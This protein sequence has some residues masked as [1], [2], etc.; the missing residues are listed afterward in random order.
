MKI[1]CPGILPTGS[2][3]NRVA[4]AFCN[5]C[6][7]VNLPRR[8]MPLHEV[9]I[10][11]RMSRDDANLQRS[12][13]KV[14]GHCAAF[15]RRLVSATITLGCPHM[16]NIS[17]AM[18]SIAT[19]EGLPKLNGAFVARSWRSRQQARPGSDA[20]NIS[21]LAELLLLLE[22]LF[23]ESPHLSTPPAGEIVCPDLDADIFQR[24]GAQV[25]VVWPLY[26]GIWIVSLGIRLNVLNTEAHDLAKKLADFVFGELVLT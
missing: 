24:L 13:P 22:P 19:H 26:T 4:L 1:K 11:G 21:P 25:A 9:Y 5:D 8:E 20:L 14:L 2:M 18:Y 6:A 16:V 15:K 3:Q 12:G 23:P 7:A 10:P 17:R